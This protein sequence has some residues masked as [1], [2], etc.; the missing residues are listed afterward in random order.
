MTCKQIE[1]EAALL[2]RNA[3]ASARENGS[4]TPEYDAIHMV[5]DTRTVVDICG[6]EHLGYLSTSD[7]KKIANAA[8]LLLENAS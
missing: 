4:R 6:C 5:D 8:M 7:L 3:I 2:A 1:R